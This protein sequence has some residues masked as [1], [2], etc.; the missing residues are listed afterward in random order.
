[1]GRELSKERSM[2]QVRL[3]IGNMYAFRQIDFVGE[4]LAENSRAFSTEQGRFE[5]VE[6]LYRADDGHLLVH[7]EKL[8]S[9]EKLYE[10]STL[11]KVQ[12]EDLAEGG[13][14]A[15]LGHKARISPPGDAT[16]AQ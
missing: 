13:E 4:V 11:R 15:E 2:E 5:V 12:E 8:P 7:V 3:L 16:E 9:S 10:F 14:F 1:M 6:T